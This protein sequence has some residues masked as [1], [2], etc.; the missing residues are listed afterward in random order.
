MN[1]YFNFF[2]DKDSKHFIM[3]SVNNSINI[4]LNKFNMKV[5]LSDLPFDYSEMTDAKLYIERIS[6]NISLFNSYVLGEINSDTI[7]FTNVVLDEGE[8]TTTYKIRLQCFNGGILFHDSI[9]SILTINLKTICENFTVDIFD[10]IK[11]NDVYELQ[12]FTDEQFEM[13]FK[14]KLSSSINSNDLFYNFIVS[15]K[16]SVEFKDAYKPLNLDIDYF[17]SILVAGSFKNNITYLHFSIKDQFG[18]ILNEKFPITTKNGTLS[19]FEILNN[20]L[21]IKYNEEFAVFYN[22]KNVESITPYITYMLNGEE[23]TQK[24][25]K[26]ISSYDKL[27]NAITIKLTDYFEIDPSFNNDIKLKFILNQDE[28]LFSNEMLLSIDSNKPKVSLSNI[29]DGYHLIT[30]ETEYYTLNGKLEDNNFFYIGSN[31]KKIDISL[32]KQMLYLYSKENIKYVS[33][34]NGEKEQVLKYSNF[35]IIESKGD[36]FNVFNSNNEEVHDFEFINDYCSSDEKNIYF[37]FKQSEFS[38]YELNI[39]GK[40]NGFK[41]KGKEIL[42]LIKKQLFS[43]FND[44]FYLK[45]TFN[46]ELINEATFTKF[47]LGIEGLQYSFLYRVNQNTCS[48]DLDNS[49]K[50]NLNFNTTRIIAIKS[51]EEVLVHKCNDTKITGTKKTIILDEVAFIAITSLENESVIVDSNFAFFEDV[52]NLVVLSYVYAKPILTLKESNVLYKNYFIKELD[53]NIYTFSLDVPV[54]Q[55]VNNYKL[56]FKDS[57]NLESFVDFIIEKNKNDIVVD[58]DETYNNYFDKTIGENGNYILTTNNDNV[59]IKFVIKN[60]SL[61]DLKGDKYLIIKSD[62]S[63]KKQK[64]LLEDNV[65]VAYI[66]FNNFE[67]NEEFEIFYNDEIKKIGSFTLSYKESIILNVSQSFVSGSNT[68]FLKYNIDSFAN[69]S[70]SQSNKKIFKCE[71][72]PNNIILIT[73]LD[74]KRFLEELNLE[75]TA[76]DK[77]HLFPSVIKNIKCIFY[78]DSVITSCSIDNSIYKDGLIASNSFDLELRTYH[79]ENIEYIKFYDIHEL[80][81]TKRNKYALFNKEKDCYIIKNIISPISPESLEISIKIKDTD[82][83]INKTLFENKIK[84]L[85][86]KNNFAFTYFIENNELNLKLTN[87]LADDYTFKKLEFYVDNKLMYTANNV[88]FSSKN[89]FFSYKVPLDKFSDT[90]SFYV[91][92]FNIFDKVNFIK[93][94]LVNCNVYNYIEAELSGFKEFSLFQKD[95][96]QNIILLSDL[97]EK[98]IFLEIED[99]FG[100]IKRI[101]PKNN[102]FSIELEQGYYTFRL[103]YQKF[104]Y[105]KIVNSY[106]V[107]VIENKEKMFDYTKDYKYFDKINEIIFRKYF[108]THFEYLSPSLIHYCNDELVEV[109]APIFEA[110]NVRFVINKKIGSNRLVYKDL[111][112][113]IELEPFEYTDGSDYNQYK[114]F[115]VHTNNQTMFYNNE[116]VIYLRNIEDLYFKTLGIT[117]VRTTTKKIRTVV[118]QKTSD[119]VT[120][121]I[122]KEFIPCTLNF[123]IGNSIVKTIDVEIDSN[124]PIRFPIF[125]QGEKIEHIDRNPLRFIPNRK[126]IFV[127][128]YNIALKYEIKHFLLNY[129]KGLAEMYHC[130]K[131]LKLSTEDKEEFILNLSQNASSTDDIKDKIKSYFKGEK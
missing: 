72:L 73:R 5:Y 105:K 91:K 99:L 9:E 41:V 52:Y 125:S 6:N 131:F 108:N 24:S 47:D 61:A 50:I 43:V 7:D 14:V 76:Y 74:N 1:F 34:D 13:K 89:T 101:S 66:N 12:S 82:L 26:I 29:K 120:T 84:L 15:P 67:K 60:E 117:E 118:K 11:I 109:I 81:I 39:I 20:E 130:D 54:E 124:E 90:Y 42:P 107:E 116:D 2:N 111:F 96:L 97:S 44:I 100:E 95:E 121:T 31:Q 103:I 55:G 48:A 45:V 122:F 23:V 98:H 27:I 25:E 69:I 46:K 77:N 110:D 68:Y 33:F 22:S 70:L 80:D 18:N 94:V 128:K 129:S 21:V 40:N 65:R 123:Y 79:K 57:N 113:K 19:L 83:I 87:L 78:N 64:I 86:D 93:S 119:Y 51:N 85:N 63:S 71:L 92:G 17:S 126:S 49:K 32:G 8:G 112:N 58:I 59:I 56:L 115:S 53:E 30:D 16:E 62:K 10:A 38:K 36:N 35:Y 102:K 88:V 75:I 127:D 104:N 114:I 37:M 28:K 3:N 4:N 106:N